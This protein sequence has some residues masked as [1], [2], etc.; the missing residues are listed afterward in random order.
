MPRRFPPR[1]SFGIQA[2]GF[3]VGHPAPT[4]WP[5]WKTTLQPCHVHHVDWSDI[6]DALALR[7]RRPMLSDPAAPDRHAL[8]FSLINPDA[9]AWPMLVYFVVV[10]GVL[11]VFGVHRYALVWTYLRRV[12]GRPAEPPPAP[13]I[14]PAVTVQLPMFNEKH[15]AT[16]LIDAVI[17]MDYPR[18]RMQI[19]VLDDSTDDSATIVRK[20]C[21]HHRRA[22]VN[23]V[24][25]HRDDRTGYKAGALAVGLESATG[26]FIAMFDADF[27][28]PPDFL[29]QAIPYFDAD[30]VGL[31]QGCWTH[32]NRDH[33]WLT[34]I[35]A[36]S[37]DGHFIVEQ[38]AKA[39]RG[40]WFNFNGTAGVW[41]RS[42]IDDA[43]GWQH[44]TLTEDTD[45]SYRAQMKGWRF[46][47]VREIE[48]PAELPPSMNAFLSQQ[49]RWSKGLVQTALKLGP[50]ILRSRAP[51]ST[52]LE[53]LMHLT[54]PLPYV[55]IF[56]L[57]LLVIPAFFTMLPL[58]FVSWKVILGLGLTCLALGTFAAGSY[59]I[60]AG[61]ATG[62]SAWRLALAVPAL[63]AV[64]IGMSAI[65][66]RA[67]LEAVF[68]R[69]SAFI[70]TPK[71]AG[72]RTSAIDPASRHHRW[73][74]RGSIEVLMGAAMTIGLA[75]ALWRPFTLVGVPFLALFAAGF[76]IVGV[77]RLRDR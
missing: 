54:S 55:A 61:V 73:L 2:D 52:R 12:R 27:V 32:L 17:A 64:G 63:M 6:V 75:L 23:I 74:P 53:A 57:A 31:V 36:L 35:Q 26:A 25:C 69:D 9:F 34:R 13:D 77:P 60:V 45:L 71:Y 43:G 33:S 48:C 47:F 38:A 72:H 3:H 11:C 16:R 8:T 21:E 20:A 39:A 14:W 40:A 7:S 28:P 18:D 19:Q 4:A 49:H 58:Y 24:Y 5:R 1:V 59:F 30:D 37:L 76:L 44:D 22:G 15:V 70:R 51:W 10:I 50:R 42:C 62:R 29:R 46:R 66:T 56:M 65:S 67:V 41:R 68:G